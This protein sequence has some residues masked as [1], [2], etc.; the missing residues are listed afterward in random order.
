VLVVYR[1]DDP[2]GIVPLSIVKERTRIGP[3]RVLTYPLHDWASFYSPL[4]SNPCAVLTAAMCHVRHE[5]DWDLLDLRWVDVEGQDG[6]ATSNAMRAAGFPSS[7]RIWKQIATVDTRGSW[8]DY[9][10][11]RTVKFRGNIR[12]LQRR[13][14]RLGQ[15]QH[16]R[17]RPLGSER[18]DVDPRWDLYETCADLSRR[19]WQGSSNTGTTLSSEAI[20][21]FMRETHQLA[22][23]R[24][25]V[26]LN[27]LL[28]DK[29]PVAFCYNY[30]FQG[31][32][33]GVRNGYDRD[34]SHAGAGTVLM[35]LQIEDSFR[36]GD[37][38]LDLGPE[39]LEIKRP[40]LTRLARSYRYTYYPPLVP[41]AQ[42]LR[43]KH[44]F[45]ERYGFARRSPN[46]VKS[47]R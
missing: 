15:V 31:R 42:V 6:G 13:I 30:H 32:V 1:G 28:I 20:R 25:A 29:R 12:R 37:R 22:V 2:Q 9:L 33:Y 8:D 4:G 35:A 11:T 3:V 7:E 5:Q 40:W 18:G 39:Y 14:H 47:P 10:A 27:L 34:A 46:S 16:V 45:R 26:D 36:R 23:R 38:L 19:S 44:W 17:Y 41:K 24:G 21:D 43:L